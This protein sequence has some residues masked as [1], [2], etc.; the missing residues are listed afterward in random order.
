MRREFA[1]G[2]LLLAALGLAVTTSAGKPTAIKNIPVTVTIADGYA[3]QDDGYGP[4]ANGVGGVNA[5][6]VSAGN[7]SLTTGST[8][9]LS[10]DFTGGCSGPCN[11]PWESGVV[12][13][14]VSTS[15]C[16]N[17]GGLRDMPLGGHQSCNLNVN[18]GTPGTGWFIRFG[19]YAGTTPAT[20]DRL[21]D[22]S[23]TIDV[24]VDG[25]GR[26]QS[27]PTKGRLVLTDRGD[28][29]MPVHMTVT[30]P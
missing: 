19:E 18:F 29:V 5:V 24:P 30:Q 9:K 15:A 13:G 23:W 20:V 28:Y 17:T 6:F 14:F 26:L 1:F 27:Y 16:D 2:V 7:L 21:P 25:I 4:Y 10:L 8:R 11:P 22:G 12:S 3:I